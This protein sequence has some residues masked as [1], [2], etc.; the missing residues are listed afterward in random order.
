MPVSAA[1]LRTEVHNLRDRLI[2]EDLAVAYSAVVQLT[3]ARGTTVTHAGAG[4][5]R[6]GGIEATD[7]FVRALRAR[8]YLCVLRDGA[9]IQVS[10]VVTDREIASHRLLY[11]PCPLDVSPDDWANGSLD[12]VIEVLEALEPDRR[13]MRG[14]IRF[15]YNRDQEADASHSQAHVHMIY[16]HCR[17]PLRGPVSLGRFIRFVCERFYP[18]VWARC[19]TLRE[20]PLGAQLNTVGAAEQ[21]NMC[22]HWSG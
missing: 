16:D 9:L 12:D 4:G 6:L 20:W 17:V 8:D 5:A 14:G 15:D 7:A 22:F 2:K 10:Y 3:T 19:D 1:S 11:Q 13:R 18:D 21:S